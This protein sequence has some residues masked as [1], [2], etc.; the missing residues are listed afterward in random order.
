MPTSA[1][2]LPRDGAV[3][4]CMLLKEEFGWFF[5]GDFK[6]RVS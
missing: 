1:E 4:S 3:V 2:Y 5:Y 6:N